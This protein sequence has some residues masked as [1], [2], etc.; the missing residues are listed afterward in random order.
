M[1]TLVKKPSTRVAELDGLCGAAILSVFIWHSFYFFPATDHNPSSHLHR[2]Y[3]LFESCIAMCWSGVDLFFILSGF[4]IG[5]ILLDAKGAP[6][7]FKTF[8]A[9]RFY[10]I[11]PLYYAWLV[12][13]I[14][15]VSLV[16]AYPGGHLSA[17]DEPGFRTILAHFFYIQNMGFNDYA[18]I[19]SAWLK[20]TWSLAVEEQF[21]LIAP[22]V[23]WFLPRRTLPT[24]FG[25]VV[26]VAPFLR[27]WAR[28]HWFVATT[29]DPAFTLMPCRADTLAIGILAAHVWRS[30]SFRDHLGNRFRLFYALW[31][32]LLA[33]V[34]ALAVWSP[35]PHSI[36]MITVGYGWLA[37][38]FAQ[39]LL[40]ALAKPGGAIAALTRTKELGALGRISYCIY[41][42][43]QAMAHF[44]ANLIPS[45]V[46]NSLA[47]RTILVPTVSAI[48]TFCLATVSWNFFE[49]GF[50]ARGHAYSYT[51]AQAVPIS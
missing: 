7:Y 29:I 12:C 25:V 31:A 49:K 1:N 4:L 21:Y 17:G 11:F 9:R 40:L 28:Y 48:L 47:L 20:T 46:V 3:I 5:G 23:I 32:T 36:P 33:G 2:L 24:F 14:L 34:I 45:L 18:G 39:T 37:M 19:S 16:R 10:R 22:L 13:Y 6:N 50:I 42:T 15:L 51:P 41:V 8:Y 44:T 26:I 27:L 30:E 38:F 43:N 35:D